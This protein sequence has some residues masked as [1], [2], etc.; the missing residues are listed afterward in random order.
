M[1]LHNISWVPPTA[2]LVSFCLSL[3]L[4]GFQVLPSVEAIGRSHPGQCIFFPAHLADTLFS[5]CI[6][7][8]TRC[9]CGN[10]PLTK[11][12]LESKQILPTVA[13]Y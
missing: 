10:T 6:N 7:Q 3:G 8:D 2:N 12:I 4:P 9:V 11:E 5:P 1:N 13:V